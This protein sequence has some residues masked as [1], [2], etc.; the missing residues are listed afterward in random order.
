[1]ATEILEKRPSPP[2]AEDRA[3]MV[4]EEDCGRAILFV[5]ETPAH[6][7]LNELH[8]TPTWNRGYIGAADRNFPRD[9]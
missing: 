3:R 1:M 8:I 7:C 5:A 4:Q 6:V 9:D 2:S